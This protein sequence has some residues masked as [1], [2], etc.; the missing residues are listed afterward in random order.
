MP[1]PV[2][3]AFGMLK[4]SCALVNMN[5]GLDKKVGDAIIQAA[6]EVDY[7]VVPSLLFLLCCVNLSRVKQFESHNFQC[8]FF[9]ILIMLEYLSRVKQF[10]SVNFKEIIALLLLL[11]VSSIRLLQGN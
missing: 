6:D 9:T 11:V 4:K 5:Y 1:E 3:R 7:E 8:S 2:I 10:E